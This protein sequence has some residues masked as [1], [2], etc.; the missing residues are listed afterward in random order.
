M[1][2]FTPISIAR[3]IKERIG[4][5]R[6]DGTRGSALYSVPFQ[7]SATPPDGWADLF[8]AAWDRPPRFTTAHRPGIASVAGDTVV[9]DGTTVEEVAKYHKAT[10]ELAVAEANHRY[11]QLRAEQDRRDEQ[12]RRRVA[13]HKARTAK[14]ADD[15]KFGDE[16][17]A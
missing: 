15:I 5:P 1:A 12:E 10:L 6:G 9:L 7:L 4:T 2:G 16:R 14:L 3:V 13:E 8:V 17:T 11:E